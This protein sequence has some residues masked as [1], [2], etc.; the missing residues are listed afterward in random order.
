MG[1]TGAREMFLATLDTYISSD[2][3]NALYEANIQ[4]TTTKNIKETYYSDN[5]RVLTFEK[6]VEICFDNVSHWK[7]FN[8]TVEQ[9]EQKNFYH[10]AN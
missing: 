6:L 1:R 2:V 7:N 9:N 10:K 5:E 8:Y 3:L 4:V